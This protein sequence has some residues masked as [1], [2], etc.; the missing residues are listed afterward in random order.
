MA[1]VQIKRCDGPGCEAKWVTYEVPL[2]DRETVLGVLD[3]IYE[4]IDTG[5][6]HYQSCREG[7]CLG[8]TVMVNGKAVLSCEA[9]AT[10][11]M[12]VGPMENFQLIRD[13]VVDFNKPVKKTK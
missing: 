3:H 10:D 2:E 5:L 6:A 11:G 7:R 1:T 9:M 8:C 12:R 13:L 4:N